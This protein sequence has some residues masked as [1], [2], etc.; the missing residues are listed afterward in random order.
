MSA[1]PPVPPCPRGV[2]CPCPMS[3]PNLPPKQPTEYQIEFGGKISL[4]CVRRPG[5]GADDK[6]ATRWQPS[7]ARPGCL[8]EP[9]P[10]T[11]PH[12][13]TTH[14]PVHDESH[15]R[16]CIAPRPNIRH[17]LRAGPV[18][19]RLPIVYH[20][21]GRHAATADVHM[22]GQQPPRGTPAT[23]DHQFELAAP[24]HPCRG[25]QHAVA[26]ARG[27]VAEIQDPPAGLVRRSG[28][29]GPYG[30]G[31]P[32]SPGLPSFASATGTRGSS[33]CGGCSA[34]RYAYSLRLQVKRC[35]PINT[36]VS[37]W[38]SYVTAGHITA[39]YLRP[40]HPR[41]RRASLGRQRIDPG[42][43]SGHAETGHIPAGAGR[44][45]PLSSPVKPAAHLERGHLPVWPSG[46]ARQLAKEEP[47]NP[48]GSTSQPPGPPANPPRTRSGSHTLV[49]RT[50]L[51]PNAAVFA[52]LGCGQRLEDM[53]RMA[54]LSADRRVRG[55]GL[56]SQLPCT[57]CG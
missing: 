11:I 36:A 29:S 14:G 5:I 54:L 17:R 7:S 25:R 34:E 43:D 23:A 31:P 18:I 21:C 51:F 35:F 47:G 8:A 41:G 53:Y 3:R 13:R 38:L 50:R 6:Q 27:P 19:R 30:G 28:G 15:P 26:P 57:S 44:L 42:A 52:R 2:A 9:P 12:D 40:T 20:S 37:S 16:Q 45:R 10:D 33:P 48:P 39:S 22:H 46:P 4:A 56:P 32:G 55:D 24:P 1:R 49:C